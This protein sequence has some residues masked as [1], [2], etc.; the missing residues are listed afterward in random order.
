M[1]IIHHLRG[2][3]KFI[4]SM[5]MMKYRGKKWKCDK[6]SASAELLNEARQKDEWSCFE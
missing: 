1:V 6:F 2:N 4:A 3:H 5:Q